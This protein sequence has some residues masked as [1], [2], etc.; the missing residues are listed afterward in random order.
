[1][2]VTGID[3]AGLTV[4][5]LERSLAFYEGLLELPLAAI[6]LE[7]S[8]EIEAIVGHPGARVRIADLQLPSG[9]V[10]ELL[11]YEVP[12]AAA[13]TASHTQAGTA[14]LALG[15]TDLRGLHARLVA[16]GVD[17]ISTD[18]PVTVT[19]GE[20]WEGVTVLY[21]RDPDRNVIELIERPDSS[22]GSAAP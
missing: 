7:E 18:G 1:V 5:D 13:V 17:V 16:A 6:A 14:H 2:T 20:G 15:V 3:H 21:V 19:A 22:S 10:L 12:A 4:A 11:Q 9:A 8:A